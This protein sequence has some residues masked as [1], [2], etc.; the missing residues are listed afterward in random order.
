MSKSLLWASALVMTGLLNSFMWAQGVN[1]EP[2]KEYALPDAPSAINANA[3][4]PIPASAIKS[5]DHDASGELVPGADP[6]NHLMLPFID[7][8]V[9]DQK[10]FW[11][12]PLHFHKSDIEW[13][14]PFA[15]LTAGFV[16]GDSWISKQVP[17]GEVNRSKT[18]S[19]YATYSLIGAGAGSF[20]LGH[21][22]GD[23]QMSET[24]L[25][26]G[27]AAINSTAVAYLFKDVAQRQRPYQ[28]NGSGE[29][30]QGGSS[31][32]SEHA[33]I[34]WSIASVM[35]HE[36]PGTLTKILAYGLATGVS[37]T[38]V[39]GQQHF[40]SDVIVGSALGWYFGR[41]VYRAHH[42]SDL[43]GSSWGSVLPEK[44]DDGVRN[45]DNMGSADV[46]LDSWIYPAMER[47]IALG[48][49]KSGYLGIR[50]W[51]RLECARLLEEAQQQIEDAGDQGGEAVRTY[52]ALAG[53]LSFETGR[54]NGAANVGMSL[55]SVY[56]R[57]TQISGT[58]LRD[59]YHF[60]QTII[61]DYGRPYGEGF[62]A[63]GGVTAHAEAGPL[64]ISVQGEYQHSPAV[65]SDPISVLQATAA[66][67]STLP[68]AN[69]TTQFDRFRLLDSTVGLT[70]H[71]TQ[72]SF[73]QQSLWLGTTESGPFLF[74]DNAEPMTMLR[75]DSVSPYQVPLI[76]KFLG[77]VRSEFFIGRLSGQNWEF[78]PVL[79]G[80]NLT[81]QPFVH[82]TKFSF[83]P[84][85]NLEF[86]LGF[87]AQF[88][89]PGNPF[90]C[91]NFL[92]TFYSHKVG[93]GNNPGKRLSEFDFNYRVPGLR[94]WLQ[95]YADS[96]VIDEYS[97]LG[98]NRP[99]IN[100]GIYLSHFPKVQKLDLRLEGITDDMNVPAHFGPGAFYWDDRYHSGY[101][102]N[103][104][105]IGS[106]IGRRGRGEQGWLTYRFSPRT[107][108]QF[109][110]RHNS[111]DRA[112]LQGG[113][114]QDFN[115][116]ADLMLTRTVGISG[117]VQRENW[118]FPVLSPTAQSDTAA[119]VQL[120]FW[121]HWNTSARK[122]Q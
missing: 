100:P 3:D 32:P 81:S 68:L 54:L 8:L 48:Y 108:I 107:D 56:A 113:M 96:M 93:V 5:G 119:S 94:N 89:G 59:G 65:A 110:Y 103:G 84:T 69:G 109:G 104:D 114:L 102:N 49:I 4:D 20:L 44:S 80:P 38:R 46:P 15:G 66:I 67:D 60:G 70:F 64:S 11:T 122:D 41:Q 117:F 120:T 34:A 86:G 87:T 23:D 31:F 17:L 42:D 63:I 105:L 12:A 106:W 95:I 47:L 39:T 121:P 1:A 45:P 14:A 6:D 90:T 16:E 2:A 77:P 19:N 72:V 74:S 53:E 52:N 33:A 112:F 115:L 58:P 21:Y 78:S 55:D 91:G 88:G 27:E 116:R 82:G 101:T 7:H 9:E 24:G 97:P 30:F 76:S 10:T 51:T 99:A 118:N 79:Y 37:A 50:P 28:G 71:N 85:D 40:P 13:I 43:G 111:V 22:K 83:H 57:T 35:A 29:F 75:I 25:L 73:G 98:S 61:N 62:N 26:S 18:F 92:K 36:Y